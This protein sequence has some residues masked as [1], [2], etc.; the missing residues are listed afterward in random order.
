MNLYKQLLALIL[1]GFFF[2]NTSTTY[3]QSLRKASN[4]FLE[5]LTYTKNLYVEEVD[6]DELTD[7]AISKMLSELDPHSEYFNKAEADNLMRRLSSSFVGIGI[8]Y[9]IINDTIFIISVL[10][11]G[12]AEKA[13]MKPGDRIIKIADKQ[14]AS[15]KIKDNDIGNLLLGKRGKPVSVN[16]KRRALD[17][18]LELIITRD[19]VKY[20]SIV[21]S[22]MLN[23]NVGYIR[24]E[25]FANSSGKEFKDSLNNLKKNGAKHLVLDLRKN[26]GGLLTQC[27]DIA[28]QFWDKSNVIVSIKGKNA[29][30][31]I[32]KSNSLAIFPKGRLIVLIDERSASASEIIAGAVQDLDRGVLLG[33]RSFGKG[34]VQRSIHLKDGSMINL[35]VAHYYTAS[36]RCIQRDYKNNYENYYKEIINRDEFETPPDSGKVFFTKNK[37]KVYGGGAIF[38]DVFVANSN[39]E[40]S[41]FYINFL[42]TGIIFNEIHL[43][44]DKHRKNIIDKYPHPEDYFKNYEIPEVLINYL[45]NKVPNSVFEN[46]PDSVTK[47][48]FNKFDK[49]HLKAMLIIDIWGDN[50]YY[51]YI[52]KFSPIISKA[53]DIIGDKNRYNSL[54]NNTNSSLN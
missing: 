6:A 11:D 17:K 37:R 22:Y 30:E 1:I 52:N 36:G 38:P 13:G 48:T 3:A 19:R 12:P 41:K 32:Y 46:L 23:K 9:S 40:F 2:I 5:V 28:N 14:V 21:A 34:L 31:Q 26:T 39:K 53:L 15:V 18:P 16:V 42:K 4:K 35:S 44:A 27:I 45:Y 47:H 24:L 25:R 43:F 51:M 54:L 20:R 8:S 50:F 49:N 33:R 10:K 7:K 29:K